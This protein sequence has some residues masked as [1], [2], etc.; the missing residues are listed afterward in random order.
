MRACCNP[1]HLFLATH[2][3]NMADCKAKARHVHGERSAQAKLTD[4]QVREI[5]RLYRKTGPRRGNGT[6]LAA[7]F[8]VSKG[9]ISEI[10]NSNRRRWSHLP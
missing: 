10:A 3:E 9:T 1:A 6:E 5:R 8:G 4:A 7:R 2:D